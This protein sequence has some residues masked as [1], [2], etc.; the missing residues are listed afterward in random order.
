MIDPVATSR[1]KMYGGEIRKYRI[2]SRN[3]LI[4][5]LFLEGPHHVWL[6]YPQSLTVELSS[7]GLRTVDVAADES[8]T[9]DEGDKADP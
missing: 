9:A 7:Y 4:Q 1:S 5:Y 6:V 8:E 3:R 2:A